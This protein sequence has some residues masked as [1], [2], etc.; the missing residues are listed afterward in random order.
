MLLSGNRNDE[1]E[2]FVDE[3]Q[4]DIS[5]LS[6]NEFLKDYTPFLP[7]STMTK[8]NK[9]PAGYSKAM[10]SILLNKNT[11]NQPKIDSK[12]A[13]SMRDVLHNNSKTHSVLGK[14]AGKDSKTSRG[15]FE[16]NSEINRAKENIENI[17]DEI[18]NISIKPSLKAKDVASLDDD[19]PDDATED[20]HEKDV[21]NGHVLRKRHVNQYHIYQ[22]DKMNYNKITEGMTS[23]RYEPSQA[24]YTQTQND[25]SD[26][27]DFDDYYEDEYNE[28]ED[29]DIS[30]SQNINSSFQDS[31]HD[32]GFLE[33]NKIVPLYSKTKN[34]K[35]TNKNERV[36]LEDSG[37]SAW[38]SDD[39]TVE[40]KEDFT[41]KRKDI[42]SDSMSRF[43][44][45]KSNE[46]ATRSQQR[47]GSLKNINI[48]SSIR[49]DNKI[50]HSK[51]KNQNGLRSD[52]KTAKTKINRFDQLLK[53]SNK[54]A[55]RNVVSLLKSAVSKTKK[56]S[57]DAENPDMA[58]NLFKVKN[59]KRRPKQKLDDF[60]QAHLEVAISTDAENEFYNIENSDDILVADQKAAQRSHQEPVSLLNSSIVEFL[61]CSGEVPYSST[62][63]SENTDI[64]TFLNNLL[65][66]NSVQILDYLKLLEYLVLGE[67]D[68][69]YTLSYFEKFI[70]A[71]RKNL[72]LPEKQSVSYLMN[73][74]FESA[75]IPILGCLAMLKNKRNEKYKSIVLAKMTNI[76]VRFINNMLKVKGNA[77]NCL[78]YETKYTFRFIV[79]HYPNQFQKIIDYYNNKAESYKILFQ[80]MIYVDLNVKVSLN[81]IV[82][83][84]DS[85]DNLYYKDIVKLKTQLNQKITDS[86]KPTFKALLKTFKHLYKPFKEELIYEEQFVF[87]LRS[88][89]KKDKHFTRNNTFFLFMRLLYKNKNLFESDEAFNLDLV[90]YLMPTIDPTSDNERILLRK[91]NMCILVAHLNY[92]NFAIALK[93]LIRIL[94][95]FSFTTS[96]LNKLYKL[97]D[98]GIAIYN[99]CFDN[100]LALFVNKH[101]QGQLDSIFF[102]S[103]IVMWFD[104]YDNKWNLLGEEL[105]NKTTVNMFA[106]FINKIYK[107]QPIKTLSSVQD[108]LEQSINID[109]HNSP[110]YKCCIAIVLSNKN[111]DTKWLK[112]QIYD[113]LFMFFKSCDSIET[114]MK[115]LEPLSKL[116][117][118]ELY[119]FK[120]FKD[121]FH[122]KDELLAIDYYLQMSALKSNQPMLF[123]QKYLLFKFLKKCIINWISRPEEYDY[124]RTLDDT[125][126]SS[127]KFIEIIK[128]YLLLTKNLLIIPHSFFAAV[129]SFLEECTFSDFKSLI[130]EIDHLDLK[131]SG[132]VKK[133]F[134]ACNLNYN[135]RL[136]QMYC[137]LLLKYGISDKIANIAKLTYELKHTSDLM[138]FVERCSRNEMGFSNLVDHLLKNDMSSFAKVYGLISIPQIRHKVDMKLIDYLKE[139]CLQVSFDIWNII[140]DLATTDP[141][142]N[143]FKKIMI[144]GTKKQNMLKKTH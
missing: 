114:Y 28:F 77:E 69:N 51:A 59:R 64:S 131:A 136:D 17:D 25:N 138:M 141:T 19:F 80:Q 83:F 9:V 10:R 55:D 85:I 57:T 88:I 14:K 117:D 102:K 11:S 48:N 58:P 103:L 106:S 95:S 75:C 30:Y 111:I 13:I 29:E 7:N 52:F 37:D 115:V 34:N 96:N 99:D 22:I 112:I 45:E 123:K 100:C 8:K 32:G 104:F 42:I 21:I 89:Y 109:D 92:K 135:K 4:H 23:A 98:L 5:D 2:D 86:D 18:R 68:I 63:D 90:N 15:D 133:L 67:Y 43:R 78:N 143:K 105:T 108:I 128:N 61:F 101:K 107:Y 140:T 1:E 56:T 62:L 130:I 26:D 31:E 20:H 76:V 39:S 27:E 124:T 44:N 139:R 127:Y 122:K 97:P 84:S 79:E 87:S 38:E 121:F 70:I 36:F 6:G 129:V 71:Y 116:P 125:E 47:W 3:S 33:Q 91:L 66:G 94:E 35:N 134:S 40:K 93:P 119:D 120:K 12:Y 53:P 132:F 46:I 73:C 49:K 50:Q 24:L 126:S 137:N 142:L 82:N 65:N 72:L 54:L 16:S 74:F 144:E 41:K 81:D 118:I 110:I 60:Y 113:K